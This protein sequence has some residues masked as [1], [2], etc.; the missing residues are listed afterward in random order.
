[1]HVV[2][3]PASC[4]QWLEQPVGG[5]SALTAALSAVH[6][7]RKQVYKKRVRE[8]GLCSRQKTKEKEEREKG[9]RPEKNMLFIWECKWGLGCI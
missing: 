1:M 4:F 2:V 8:E 5:E 3:L 6:W 7:A 9:E